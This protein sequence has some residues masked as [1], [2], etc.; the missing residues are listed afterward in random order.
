MSKI[1]SLHAEEVLKRGDEVGWFVT[2]STGRKKAQRSTV[3]VPYDWTLGQVLDYLKMRFP[4]YDWYT[5]QPI[6][7]R[8][9][10]AF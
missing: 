9:P 7:S 4:N 1:K 6:L 2:L 8:E 5:L 3:Y 10:R